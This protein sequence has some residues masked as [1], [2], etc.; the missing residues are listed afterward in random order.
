MYFLDSNIILYA[1]EVHADPKKS[2]IALR[3]FEK[4]AIISAQ[5]LAEVCSVLQRKK[6][7]TPQQC[8]EVVADLE[9]SF[10][11]VPVTTQIVREAVRIRK[12]YGYAQYDCQILAAALEAG[13]Y[14]VYSE[15]MHHGLRIDGG[16]TILNP[17]A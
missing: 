11:I 14:T 15:D 6:E 8:L 3:L 9:A 16:L 2:A 1:L 17:F 13:C 7:A 5:V 4:D 10:R 12:V